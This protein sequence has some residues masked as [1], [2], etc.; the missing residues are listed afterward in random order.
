[1]IPKKTNP[2]SF[3]LVTIGIPTFNRAAL[4]EQTL[5]SAIEQNY[6]NI[7]IIVSDNASTDDTSQICTLLQKKYNNISYI[8]QTT[9]IGATE[10]FN[11]VLQ[12]AKGEYFMWLG[13]DDWIDK[14]YISECQRV[15]EEH[16]DTEM[17]AG[18]PM[19]YYE[20]TYLYTG[21]AMNIDNESPI[22]RVSDYFSLVQHNGIFYGLMRTQNIQKHGLKNVMGGDLLTIA[23]M[24]F[25][26]KAY[27]LKTCALHRRRGGCSSDGKSLASSLELPW[28][29]H[30]FPR[31]S[32]A[33]NIFQHIVYDDTFSSLSVFQRYM[34]AL[35]C[36]SLAFYRKVLTILF[37]NKFM[38]KAGIPDI[39]SDKAN[40]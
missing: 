32:L 18:M 40:H 39:T 2:S 9:N 23:S 36:V 27:T 4:I 38:E 19:Y 7:E 11:F 24:V 8:Q 20:D 35:K 10:N 12:Q 25:A 14:N 34:L 37:K 3:P 15:L 13:D 26:G 17:I 22:Q 31:L 33:H 21:F 16:H 5:Q 30:Y 29:D 6:P 1:M 28:L